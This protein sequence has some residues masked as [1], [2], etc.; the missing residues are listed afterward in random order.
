MNGV[1]NK[2]E[3]LVKEIAKLPVHEV[4]GS[5]DEEIQVAESSGEEDVSKG[6]KAT[7]KRNSNRKTKTKSASG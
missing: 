3:K 6:S 4:D 5:D 2:T 1:E 7:T